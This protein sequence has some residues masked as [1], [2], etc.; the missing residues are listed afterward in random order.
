MHLIHS[1]CGPFTQNK[2]RNKNLKKQDKACCQDDMAYGDYK[3]LARRRASDTVLCDHAFNI[4]K[5]PKYDGYQRGIVSVVY[6][7][8]D[9]KSSGDV[10][11]CA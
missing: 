7:F 3:N 6:K 8:F 11:T 5:N 10:V 9:K 1:A 4:A 2:E